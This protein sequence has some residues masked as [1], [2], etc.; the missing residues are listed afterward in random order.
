MSHTFG[1]TSIDR[2]GCSWGSVGA[3]TDI[4]SAVVILQV[5]KLIAFDAKSLSVDG[6]LRAFLSDTNKKR[7]QVMS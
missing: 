1:R 4:K 6:A 5:E 3:G 2:A 7:G